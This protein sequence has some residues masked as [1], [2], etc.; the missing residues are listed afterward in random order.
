MPTQDLVNHIFQ[1]NCVTN[2]APIIERLRE[3]LA[4]LQL[5]LRLS[6]DLHL[7][8]AGQF[9]STVVLTEAVGKQASGWL[10]YARGRA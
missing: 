5:Q 9:G 7:I 2:K 10:K 8:S 6:K 4:V 3:R 1:A